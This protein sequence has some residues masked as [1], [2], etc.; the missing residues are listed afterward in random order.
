[1]VFRY[2]DVDGDKVTVA[3]SSDTLNSGL[4]TSVASGVGE[5][6]QKLDL[7]GG[8]FDGAS[9]TFSVVKVP[10]GD[11]LAN[12]GYINAT[13]HDLGTVTVKG[14]LGQID[15][16]SGSATVPAIKSLAV[17]SLGRF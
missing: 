3:V 4:F 12:V 9:L 13:G 10:G 17:N 7:S 15:A 16:G 11:G 8:G 5:Q 2:T 1:A 14:D 6:L